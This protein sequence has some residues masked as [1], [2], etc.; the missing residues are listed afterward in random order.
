MLISHL[1]SVTADWPSNNILVSLMHAEVHMGDGFVCT[2]AD[3][4][5][6]DT[7]VREAVQHPGNI[8]LCV[9]TRWRDRYADRTDH[10]EDDAEKVSVQ[11]DR[12]RRIA[13]DIPTA[14]ADGEYIG[15]ASF[16]P[17]GAE[18]LRRHYHRVRESFAGRSWRGAAVFEKAYLIPLFAQMIEEGVDIRFVP[19][20]GDYVEIDTEEDHRLA[21][22][23]WIRN[24]RDDS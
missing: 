7:V 17:K 13:R 9:D 11:G 12:V 2:Y 15:V 1:I 18:L 16:S 6:R 23:V 21:N 14:E 20:H 19:T 8:V 10:P 24:F 5:F 3:I 22:E 4:L